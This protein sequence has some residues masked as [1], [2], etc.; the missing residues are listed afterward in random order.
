[1]PVGYALPEHGRPS[2]LIQYSSEGHPCG[3]CAASQDSVGEMN[4]LAAAAAVAGAAAVAEK[5]AAH[6]DDTCH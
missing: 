6:G 3:H 5:A 2:A 1:V 4:V